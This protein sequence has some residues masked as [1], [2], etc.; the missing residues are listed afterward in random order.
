MRYYQVTRY[1]AGCFFLAIPFATQAQTSAHN[2]ITLDD[3]LNK[4]RPA[5][6]YQMGVDNVA[7]VCSLMFKALNEPTITPPF[8][9]KKIYDQGKPIPV[10]KHWYSA[11][12]S[13]YST[14]DWQTL[15]PYHVL[16]PVERALVDLDHDGK[17]EAVYRYGST[18]GGSK[19]LY[20]LMLRTQDFPLKELIYSYP[21]QSEILRNK[22][23]V[24]H[25]KRFPIGVGDSK[26][27]LFINVDGLPEGLPSQDYFVNGRHEGYK[28]I[29]D[30]KSKHYLL[31][32]HWDFYNRDPFS[33]YMLSVQSNTQQKLMCRFDSRYTITYQNH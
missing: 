25:F 31:L 18:G 10:I 7:P 27:K 28:E 24:R 3:F 33:V 30:I 5:N 6:F 13:R 32:L 14:I 29:V 22:F 16:S 26:A 8:Y 9:N 2:Q 17:E 11:M 21:R 1:L 23:N 4:G 15:V 19:F 20:N 12:H